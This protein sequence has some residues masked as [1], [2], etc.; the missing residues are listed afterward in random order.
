MQSPSPDIHAILKTVWGYEDFRPQQEQIICAAMQGRDVLALLPTGGGKSLCFQIPALAMPG[1]CLVVTPLVALMKDQVRQLGRR[2]VKAVALHAG[3]S[4]REI[5]ISLDN[6]IYDAKVKLLYVSPERLKSRL[7][8]ERLQRMKICLIA[9]DEAHCI[10]QWGY[11]F[12]PSYLQICEIRTLLPGVPVMAL[13]A[14][15]TRQVREDIAHLLGFPK[16]HAFFSQSFFRPNL[17]YTCYEGN[18]EQKLLAALKGV[19]GSALV[20]LRNRK[21]TEHLATWLSE[22]GIV[23]ESYHAGLSNAIRS[24]RQERWVV[25]ET[26]VM[27]CTNAFGMGIDKPDVRLVIH[28]DVPDTLEAYYQEVGRAGR[29]GGKA[30]GLLCYNASELQELL[31]RQLAAYPP[32]PFLRTVYQ[33]LANHYKLAVGSGEMASFD[34]DMVAFAKNARIDPLAT[35]HALQELERQGFIEIA[36]HSFGESR[37]MLRESREA[38]YPMQ[39]ANARFD[40]LL[41]ALLRLYGGGLFSD[42]AAISEEKLALFCHMSQEQVVRLLTEYDAQGI[43]VYEPHRA[44]PQLTFLQPRFAADRLPVKVKDMEARK[45]RSLKRI[46]AMT[47]F[48]KE[49]VRCRAVMVSEYFDEEL[50][51]PCG[52]CDNCLSAK[53]QGQALVDASLEERVKYALADGP[54]G[55]ADLSAKVRPMNRETYVTLLRRMLDAGEIFLSPNRTLGIKR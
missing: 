53:K 35:H 22:R 5:D 45:D 21:G 39:V 6:C 12:R 25:G 1:I 52:V 27:V 42:F 38:V 26:R 24:A 11:D 20:Y 14:T 32:I 10:S 54:L 41:K 30:Y 50:P 33:A 29:D 48:V 4:R 40:T 7:F 49:R 36:D 43:W 47:F 3:L 51:Q 37:L 28:Y 18:K 2:G 55:F 9:V 13:T 44:I 15:A 31:A 19:D 34:F 23:A 16:D 8:Q 17:V 46:E